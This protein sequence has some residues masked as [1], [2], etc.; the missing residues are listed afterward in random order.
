M[1]IT[2]ELRE[3]I[4]VGAS[5]LE[6]RRKAI[7]EGMIT[8]RRQ[9]PAQGQ[10]RRHDDRRGRAGDGEV[11]EPETS[12]RVGVAMGFEL[13]DDMTLTGTAEEDG[14]TGGLRPAPHDQTPPQV[15]VHGQLQR[16]EGP[17]LTP[18]RHQGARLQRA[19]RR[20][21]EAL[22][23][24]ARA[25]LLVRHPGLARF[26]C[27]M[28]NQRGAVGAVY[29]LIPEKIRS[30]PGARACRRCWQRSPSGRAASCSSPVRP[31]AASRRRWRR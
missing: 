13:E 2:E 1:E 28:F 30:V 16:L 22:R 27:N 8:L 5:A 23:G 7:D 29:R 4:L 20:A 10:G 25:R 18:V 15:R 17:D 11:D 9:R 21:E 19:D 12:V 3:L 31:A 6:L 14:R 24:D 26:R